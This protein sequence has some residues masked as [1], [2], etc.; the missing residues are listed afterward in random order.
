MV[1]HVVAKFGLEAEYVRK[2]ALEGGVPILA[3]Q[4]VMT[5]DANLDAFVDDLGEMGEE[6]LDGMLWNLS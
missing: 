4:T 5:T 6:D 2:S 3:E 1:A